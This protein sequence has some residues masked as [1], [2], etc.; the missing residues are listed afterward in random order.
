[1]LIHF[2]DIERF[3]ETLITRRR[4]ATNKSVVGVQKV[5]YD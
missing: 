3:L 5:L 1:M 2:L 4:C